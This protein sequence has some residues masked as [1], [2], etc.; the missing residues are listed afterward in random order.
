MAFLDW[1][2]NHPSKAPEQKQ[3]FLLSEI[4]MKP[5]RSIKKKKKDSATGPITFRNAFII[6][7]CYGFIV[8]DTG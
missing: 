3:V 7:S 4:S 1:A 6:K 2:S 8:K 5:M